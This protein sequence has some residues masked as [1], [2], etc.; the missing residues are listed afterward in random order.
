MN[1]ARYQS[2]RQE[3]DEYL[4]NLPERGK[5]FATPVAKALGRNGRP[6][7]QL[8]LE[9]L[10]ANRITPVTASRYLDLKFEHFDK[11]KA[12]VQG[13]PSALAGDD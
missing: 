9:A 10:S 1:W 7:T 5:G 4:I 13:G 2:W 11:L 8:V 3:W 6:F 12:A